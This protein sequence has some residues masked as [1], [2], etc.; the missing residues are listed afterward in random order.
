MNNFI[1]IYLKKIL[2]IMPKSSIK[3]KYQQAPTS[4]NDS[5]NASSVKKLIETDIT[6]SELYFADSREKRITYAYISKNSIACKNEENQINKTY[7]NS[8]NI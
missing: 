6:L 1:L 8:L 3:F 2:F 7:K 4:Q 5:F